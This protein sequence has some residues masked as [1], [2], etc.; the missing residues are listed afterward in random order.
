MEIEVRPEPT[1]EERAAILE[2]LE[3]ERRE[4]PPPWAQTA[5][6]QGEDTLEP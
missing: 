5:F 4:E 6:P 1:P 2:A 3:A